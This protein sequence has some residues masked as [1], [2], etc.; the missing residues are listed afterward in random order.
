MF[1][2]LPSDSTPHIKDN[3]ASHDMY[4]DIVRNITRELKS[5]FNSTPV[6][7]VFGNHD[8][9]PAHQFPPNNNLM[10]N[11]IYEGWKDWIND[12]GQKTN[13]Q[14]GI[15]IFVHSGYIYFYCLFD[16]L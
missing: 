1:P 12:D 11:E 10:Y 15:R 13:F 7:P 5:K 8:Y 6:Y 3:V 2:F 14:K 16:S 4:R 9:Y